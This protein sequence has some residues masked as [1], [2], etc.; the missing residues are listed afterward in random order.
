MN[1]STMFAALLA[2]ASLTACQKPATVVN[3]PP[4]SVGEPG[5]AGPQGSP[6]A[7]GDAGKPGDAATVI[8]V[9][10]ASSPSN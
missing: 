8:V 10:P 3:V 2:L 7:K 6:G 4:A 9:P 5:P 1:H